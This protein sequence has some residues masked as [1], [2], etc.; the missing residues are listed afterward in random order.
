[1]IAQVQPFTTLDILVLLSYFQMKLAILGSSK[2]GIH[3][4]LV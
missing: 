2:D 3:N 1:M 4:F